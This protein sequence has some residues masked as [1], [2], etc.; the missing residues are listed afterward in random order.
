MG[1]SCKGIDRLGG[2]LVG[3]MD[4]CGGQS[5]KS[6]LKTVTEIVGV[7]ETR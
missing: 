3:Q 7:W 4:T 2:G 6:G 5:Y 1:D